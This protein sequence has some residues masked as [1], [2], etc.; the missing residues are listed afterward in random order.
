M[1][2]VAVTS[3]ARKRVR[4]GE[5]KSRTFLG[6][7]A[8]AR[9]DSHEETIVVGAGCCSFCGGWG[10]CEVQPWCARN[11]EHE[12]DRRGVSRLRLLGEDRCG[13]GAQGGLFQLWWGE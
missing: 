10:H 8:L 9:G 2:A 5:A 3:F 7:A 11:V 6:K 1:I 4:A 13:E 12:T